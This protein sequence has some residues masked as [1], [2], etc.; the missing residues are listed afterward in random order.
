MVE[1][2]TRVEG[3][4]FTHNVG[5]VLEHLKHPLKMV[6]RYWSPVSD[7]GQTARVCGDIVAPYISKLCGTDDV[8][9]HS[10]FSDS[11]V[12]FLDGMVDGPV[13]MGPADMVDGHRAYHPGVL[14]LDLE[15][16]WQSSGR[17][18]RHFQINY[19]RSL[20]I[21]VC[22]AA[23]NQLPRDRGGVMSTRVRTASG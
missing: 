10:L 16:A 14:F 6:N 1:T 3:H 21:T 15:R 19:P 9:L 17:L 4:V 12:S 13:Q 7:C 18:L 2:S 23:W 20:S 5:W 22:V 8:C 11:H